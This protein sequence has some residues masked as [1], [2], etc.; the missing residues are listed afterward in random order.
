VRQQEGIR[1]DKG[2]SQAWGHLDDIVK[3]G[4]RKLKT[5]GGAGTA[6]AVVDAD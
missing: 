3:Q 2:G 1:W 6:A 5:E 4:P